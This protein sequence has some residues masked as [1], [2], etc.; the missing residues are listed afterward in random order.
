MDAELRGASQYTADKKEKAAEPA[1]LKIQFAA[2]KSQFAVLKSSSGIE[3]LAARLRVKDTAAIPLP[4]PTS[5]PDMDAK[6]RGTSQYT[7]DK[8]EKAAEPAG[9]KIQFAV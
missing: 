1:G 4:T 6:P 7:A 5:C 3:N 9:L 2:L 8:K